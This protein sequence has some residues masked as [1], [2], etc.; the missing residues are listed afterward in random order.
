MRRKLAPTWWPRELPP[1]V[2]PPPPA[3]VPPLEETKIDP[4]ATM[5]E[6]LSKHRENVSCASCHDRI[7][8]LGFGL[9]NYDAIGA[10]R[11]EDKGQAV[12]SSGVLPDGSS[13]SGPA[14]LRQILTSRK[15]EFARCLAEKMLTYALG[16][17][18]EDYDEPVLNDILEAIAE[19]DYRFSELVYQIARSLPFTKQ[20]G[21]AEAS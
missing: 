13:F 15:D 9:E 16:R 4:N 2:T 11:T 3:G 10:W 12:D 7:D 1:E 14:E 6:K 21:E 18:L 20:R 8:P 19:K 5:R 17:G